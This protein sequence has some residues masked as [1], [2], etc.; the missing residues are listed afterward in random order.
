MLLRWKRF[1]A[2]V[3][4]TAALL[5][6]LW[7]VG[8]FAADVEVPIP[9]VDAVHE[10]IAEWAGFASTGDID[11]IESG[12]AVGGPQR[13]QFVQEATIWVDN[14]Y[15]EPLRFTLRELRLRSATPEVAT[16]WVRVEATRAGFKAQEFSWDFDLIKSD[17]RWQ[18]WTVVE[19]L[20]PATE[21]AEPNHTPV[22]TNAMA[23]PAP[24]ESFEP[25][26]D[27]PVPG[28]S[29]SHPERTRIP[30]LSAWIIVI[31]IVGVALA[32]YLAPRIDRRTDP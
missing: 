10:A 26:A 1:A 28:S 27:V 8:V 16:V 11:A 20:P 4:S 32:G 12:F 18:V 19:A 17:G 3:T 22:T 23:V 5:I 6:F 21:W 25:D 7:P 30:A 13:Q 2:L 29:D 14:P 31:T 24:E 9:L 15:P